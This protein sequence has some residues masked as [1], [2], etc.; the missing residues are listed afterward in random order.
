MTAVLK[1][2]RRSRHSTTTPRAQVTFHAQDGQALVEFALILP[3]L[4]AAVVGLLVFSRAMNYNEQA[5]HLANEAARYAAVGQVPA[6]A[7]STLGAWVR[8]QAVG[9]LKSGT[10]SISGLPQVCVS[11]PNGTANIGDPVQI[12]MSFNWKWLPVLH[13]SVASTP[14]SESTA[15][16]LEAPA[17]GTF[18]ATGCS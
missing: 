4:L 8:S 17:S 5:T 10:G 7:T 9:E 6:D 15:M 11:Y 2:F 16:R 18:Y 3:V 13:L 1:N 12:T 14:I